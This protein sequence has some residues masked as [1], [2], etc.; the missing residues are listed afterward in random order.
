MRGAPP[1]RNCPGRRRTA[2]SSC[3]RN[4]CLPP[5]MPN[6]PLPTVGSRI[7]VRVR[8]RGR[9]RAPR[10]RRRRTPR[11]RRQLPATEPRDFRR[12][13]R[14]RRPRST[15]PPRCSRR[16]LRP[17]SAPA[18]ARP[19]ALARRLL[20]HPRRHR[21]GALLASGRPLGR[22]LHGS[23]VDPRR[24]HAS[25]CS[26]SSRSG[27]RG[28]AT[29]ACGGAIRGGCSSCWAPS[30]SPS[31]SSSRSRSPTSSPTP[32]A[33]TFP[34]PISATAYEEVQFTTSDGL[35]LSGWYI[36]SRNGA[37]VISFPGRASVAATREAA[38]TAR[39]RR[40]A[41]RPSR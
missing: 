41:L 30:S 14:P 19:I 27:R 32:P 35:Q 3:E 21:G 5:L 13:P 37:A 15:R 20:R 38:G 22:R 40:P 23:P 12:R 39:L 36:P 6:A 25:R 2:S 18:R 34:P 11:R 29:T 1:A 7:A 4:P 8:Q 17:S 26:A 10:D 16:L 24:I 31:P 33:P 28:G 9:P